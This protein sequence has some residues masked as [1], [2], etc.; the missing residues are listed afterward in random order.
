MLCKRVP[1]VRTNELEQLLLRTRQ[2]ATEASKGVLAQ[3]PCSA[4][5]IEDRGKTLIRHARTTLDTETLREHTVKDAKVIWAVCY[6]QR[7]PPRPPHNGARSNDLLQLDLQR[8]PS[9][10]VTSITYEYAFAHA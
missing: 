2:I 5:H 1:R 4:S 7:C 10:G 6:V 8:P 3:E 9:L